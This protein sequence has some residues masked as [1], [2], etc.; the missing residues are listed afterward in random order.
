MTQ[1]RHSILTAPLAKAAAL[2]NSPQSKHLQAKIQSQVSPQ[3]ARLLPNIPEPVLLKL[4]QLISP[5]KR[6]ESADP[7]MQLIMAATSKQGGLVTEDIKA[8]RRRFNQTT[9]LLQSMQRDVPDI[10]SVKDLSFD[11]RQGDAIK[12]RHYLPNVAGSTGKDKPPS[13]FPLIVFFHGGGF[14]LGDIESH[15]EFCYY[16]CHYTGFCVLSVDYRLAPEAPAPAASED[17]IDAVLWAAKQHQTLAFKSGQIIVCG[18]SAGG[19]LATV[20]SQQLSLSGLTAADNL[21]DS[22]AT[23]SAQGT[24]HASTPVPIM[25]WLI[26]PVTDN[27]RGQSHYPSYQKYG[28]G[29]LLSLEDKALFKQFYLG[30]S[31]LDKL[32]PLVSPIHGKLDNLP[33]AFVVTAELDV[34]S[35]EGEAY[36]QKLKACGNKVELIKAPGMP[37]GFVNLTSLHPGARQI[38]ID[39]IESMREFYFAVYDE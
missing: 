5:A 33:P 34:L 16:L 36:A 18:D 8:S 28:S 21:T 12:L 19:N 20:V 30:N 4:V 1:S 35:D 32:D 2:A 17:C 29:T 25:Q 9:V 15:D 11:N 24:T 22:S 38:T 39:M 27:E 26:Y 23:S 6:F 37:H 10:A 14:S 13:E 3:V 31:S 7:L